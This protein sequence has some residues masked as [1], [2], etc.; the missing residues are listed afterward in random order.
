MLLH[1]DSILFTLVTVVMRHVEPGRHK[2]E[3]TGLRCMYEIMKGL[4]CEHFF[5]VV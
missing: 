3:P 4:T 5:L 1:F 2:T